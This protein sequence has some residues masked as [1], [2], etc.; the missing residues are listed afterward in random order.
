MMALNS[1]PQPSASADSVRRQIALSLANTRDRL[2]QFLTPRP[3]A[4]LMAGFFGIERKR[5]RILDPG[6][7]VGGLTAA[8]VE[9]LISRE[10]RPEQISVTCYEID[11]RLVGQLEKTLSNC[12]DHCR[13]ANVRFAFNIRREDY[14]AARTGADLALFA[15][16]ADETFDCVIL[17]PPYRKINNGSATRRQLSTAGIATTNLYSAFMLLAAKQ[18]DLDGEFVSISPRSFCNGPYFQFFRRAFLHMIAIR[19]IHLFESRS[20][21]FKDDGILQENVIIHGVRS[22]EPVDRIEVSITGDDGTM[23]HRVVEANQIVR[24]NDPESII[25]IMTESRTGL[26]ADR[27]RQLPATLNSLGIT[28]STGRVVDFRVREHLRDKRLSQDVPLIF[29]T[30]LRNGQIEWPQEN[31]R[32]P[33]AIAMNSSTDDLLLP[34]AWYVLT[35]RFSAKEE[36]RRIV[37]AVYDPTLINSRFV[38]FD[39]K[40]NYFHAQGHG[41]DK[42]LAR[43]LAVFLNSTAVDEY[44]R[45]FSGHTQVNAADLRRLRYPAIHQ[46]NELAEGVSDVGDQAA[47]DAAVSR[48]Y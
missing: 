48:L 34:N 46:L 26:A 16:G 10:G 35:K 5:V 22:A 23:S 19:R 36:R 29:P 47:V 9:R 30:H 14:I 21:A 7:G 4:E 42:Q 20:F 1:F 41:L 32:K 31:G 24:S 39:N 25:H 13:R 28:V 45:T 12:R 2:G 33:N 11:A 40:T 44:F 6:A 3:I 18:L 15:E 8:L 43:G 38:G 17:N 27:I 37:A